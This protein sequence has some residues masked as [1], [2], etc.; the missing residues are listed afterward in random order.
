MGED[1]IDGGIHKTRGNCAHR[2]DYYEI[3][4]KYKTVE[5]MQKG[6]REKTKTRT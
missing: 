6:S 1:S 2:P 4:P 3:A 5:K